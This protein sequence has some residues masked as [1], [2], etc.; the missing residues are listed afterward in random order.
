MIIRKYSIGCQI[1]FKSNRLG[2]FTCKSITVKINVLNVSNFI[3]IVERL[4]I[5]CMVINMFFGV[6]IYFKTSVWYIIFQMTPVT[7]INTWDISKR[8]TKLR[9]KSEG[10]KGGS[11][12]FRWVIIPNGFY[13]ERFYSEGLLFRSFGIRNFGIKIF[14]WKYDPSG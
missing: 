7:N 8:Y 12:I 3:H 14:V 13:F 5:Y 4:H 1:G 2:I 10:Q 11:S 6:F 9:T